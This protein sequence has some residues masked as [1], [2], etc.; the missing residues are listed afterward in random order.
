MSLRR[1]VVEVQVL[2]PRVVDQTGS[3]RKLNDLEK[4]AYLSAAYRAFQKRE[5]EEDGCTPTN[6][7]QGVKSTLRLGH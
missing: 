2:S 3:I 1:S 6:K 7:L 5:D 4:A